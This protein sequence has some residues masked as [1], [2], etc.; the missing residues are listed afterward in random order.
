MAGIYVHVPFCKQA[1][2]YCDFYFVTQTELIQSFVDALIFEIKSWEN[3]SVFNQ[4]L[5]TLYFGGGTPSRL[6]KQHWTQIFEAFEPILKKNHIEEIT[7]EVNPDDVSE[8]YLETL[9]SV[10]VTRLSMGVQSFNEPL[11]RFM[12]RA[13]SANEAKNAIHLIK[14]ADF[15]S[16][17]LDMIYGN[18]NQSLDDLSTDLDTFLSFNPPHIS[19]YSLTIEPRTRL[20][21]AL[22]LGRLKA[23]DEEMLADHFVLVRNRLEQAGFIAYEVSNFAQK[24]HQA[25]HNS[26]YWK[27]ESYIGFG[28]GAHSFLWKNETTATRWQHAADLKKYIINPLQKVDDLELNLA[29]LAEERLLIGLRTLEG[30]S[31]EEMEKRYSYRLNS[32]QFDFLK[33]YEE[34]GFLNLKYNHI[35]LNRNGLL[36]ADKIVLELISLNDG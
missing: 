11:L 3:H 12:N 14:Q 26:N 16:Y 2:S 19:A 1:C 24:G 8:S 34:L 18:P 13:H 31:L 20:G 6:E 32:S 21:K 30:I 4:N 7:V 15:K 29:E 28:P 17:T 10:G 22:E 23:T 25:V 27:H 36:L 5:R 9:K 35:H 33:R